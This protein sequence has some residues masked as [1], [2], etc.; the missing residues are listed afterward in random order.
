[1]HSTLGKIFP[2]PRPVKIGAETV[3]VLEAQIKHLAFLQNYLESQIPHPF[4]F[5][6]D[7]PREGESEA[8]WLA[9]AQRA[10]ADSESWRPSY[11]EPETMDRVDQVTML[12]IIFGMAFRDQGPDVPVPDRAACLAMIATAE[13][14]AITEVLGIFF[15]R[16]LDRALAKL[17][18]PDFG[19]G[20]MAA[21]DEGTTWTEQVEI[22]L[23]NRPGMTYED[24]GELYFSQW[25]NILCGGKPG[26]IEASIAVDPSMFENKESS[27]NHLVELSRRQRIK[28]YGT[29]V[30]ESRKSALEE[31]AERIIQDVIRRDNLDSRDDDDGWVMPAKKPDEE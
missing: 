4:H 31:K 22:V 29:E 20:E 8:D 7:G 9:R 23:G 13:I 28:F 1:M 2:F 18:D 12:A 25:K 26:E 30:I 27:S 6:K 10:Y 24:I 15:A 21:D 14:H 16:D 5:V 19:T 3:M 11:G 17:I